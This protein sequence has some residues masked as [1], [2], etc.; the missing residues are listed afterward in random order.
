MIGCTF[1][2]H[3][4]FLGSMEWVLRLDGGDQMGDADKLEEFALVLKVCQSHKTL[5]A[6]RKAAALGLILSQISSSSHKKYK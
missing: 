1:L 2:P 6:G 4:A 3:A 5:G